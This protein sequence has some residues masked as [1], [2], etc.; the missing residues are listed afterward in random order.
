MSKK[1]AKIV[2]YILLPL[3][4]GIVLSK[5]THHSIDSQDNLTETVLTTPLT[6]EEGNSSITVFPKAKEV[7][8]FILEDHHG[9]E[10]TKED[11]QGHWSF[12]FFGYT[13]CPDI[14]PTTLALLSQVDGILKKEA[15]SVIPKTIFISV[16]PKRDTRTALADYVAYFNPNFLGVSGDL[17]QLRHLTRQLGLVFGPEDG[18]DAE[19]YEVYH[20]ARIMLIDPQARLRALLSPPHVAKTIA[21]HYKEIINNFNS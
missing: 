9:M 14:C 6:K 5:Y 16:D 3:F 13:H 15:P 17:H 10:F 12:L 8:A 7:T 4:L 21:E 19:N 18:G 11:L 1:S 2:I 20:S